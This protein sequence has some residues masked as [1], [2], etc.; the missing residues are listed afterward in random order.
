MLGRLGMSVDE[1]IENYTKLSAK[2]FELKRSQVNYI[3]R[4]TD[5]WKTD[6]TCREDNLSDEFKRVAGEKAGDAEA[7]LYCP[8]TPC[9]V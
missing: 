9:K 8:E 4:V 3:G 6:G 5:W 2:A 7:L 1:C